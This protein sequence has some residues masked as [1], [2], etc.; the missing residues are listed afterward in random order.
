MALRSKVMTGVLNL[1]ERQRN[2]ETIDNG[3][4]KLVVESFGM[5]PASLLNMES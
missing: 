3:L 5:W 2:G 1:V 4:I